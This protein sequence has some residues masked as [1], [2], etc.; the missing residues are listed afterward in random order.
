MDYL[1]LHQ[2]PRT[3][4]EEHSFRQALSQMHR[5]FSHESWP[6]FRLVSVPHNAANAQPY[7]QRR[8]CI[9]ESK[10][11]SLGAQGLITIDH[12]NANANAPT[13][14]PLSP[15]RAMQQLHLLLGVLRQQDDV[16][17]IMRHLYSEVYADVA[18]KTQEWRGTGWGTDELDELLRTLE[19]F[20]Y[21]KVV[22][23]RD[24]REDLMDPH[25]VGGVRQ[26]LKERGGRLVFL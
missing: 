3:A 14:A 13:L 6:V 9:F 19:D 2:S 5:V 7:D 26:V 1:S 16:M 12:G 17:D 10:L 4:E 18:R 11:A 20:E 21:L 22:Y 24:A 15:D 25:V 8:W 23:L